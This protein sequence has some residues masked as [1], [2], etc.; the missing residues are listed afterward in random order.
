MRALEKKLNLDHL[1]IEAMI[2]FLALQVRRMKPD[3][4]VGVTRGGLIPAVHLSHD[5][6]VPMV[7]LQWQTR[8]DETKEDS[9]VIKNA[10]KAKK[11]VV[12]VDDIND[13]GK[14]FEEIKNEYQGGKYVS[15]VER[16][17]TTFETDAKSLLLEDDRWVHFYWE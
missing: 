4:I 12:F 1:E 5:L 13:T 11:T 6:E 17:T 16:Y 3:L 7:T 15:L 10:I 9:K 14:T 2:N 8:D